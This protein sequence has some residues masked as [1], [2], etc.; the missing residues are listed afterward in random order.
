MIKKLTWQSVLLVF[1]LV[2]AIATASL[3][4]ASAPKPIEVL[5]KNTSP[6]QQVIVPL[7]QLG[8]FELGIVSETID[9]G[10]D[11]G[12]LLYLTS[13]LNEIQWE[14]CC[15]FNRQAIMVDELTGTAVIITTASDLN[16]FRSDKARGQLSQLIHIKPLSVYQKP[17]G[18]YKYKQTAKNLRYLTR[19]QLS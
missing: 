5:E 6:V 13:S 2:L 8:T 12:D 18:F 10:S 4:A 9:S 14:S 19:Q 16:L 1:A 17:V 11:S 15:L 7:E 3:H